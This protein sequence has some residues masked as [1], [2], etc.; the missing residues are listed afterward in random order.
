MRTVAKH[1]NICIML[2]L[3]AGLVEGSATDKSTIYTCT[4]S[5]E[6]VLHSELAQR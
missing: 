6:K 3:I 4:E 5:A 2:L 1:Y